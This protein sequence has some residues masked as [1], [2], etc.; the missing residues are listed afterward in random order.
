MKEFRKIAVIGPEST[1]KS[2]LC[3]QLANHF[4][5]LYCPEFARDFLLEN[6]NIYTYE[7]L[8]TIAKGQ[9]K[10]EEKYVQKFKKKPGILFIDTEMYVMKVWSEFVFDKCD[11]WILHQIVN[12]KYDLYLLCNPD[13][14]WIK[15]NLREYPDPATRKK[16]YSIYIDILINQP[17]PWVEITG[18]YEMRLSSA[19][20]AINKFIVF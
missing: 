12:R 13:I 17:I 8:L 5:T 19:I 20:D 10:L 14:P 11:P 15:D 1:G 9:I 4:N 6:G 3:E 18:D 2:T 16:L 7:D